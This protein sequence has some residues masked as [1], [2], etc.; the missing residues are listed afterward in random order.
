MSNELFD[1]VEIEF[2]QGDLVEVVNTGER[3]FFGR[4]EYSCNWVYTV[5]C[6]RENHMGSYNAAELRLVN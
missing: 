4:A 3:F 2:N 5:W 6:R 1:R